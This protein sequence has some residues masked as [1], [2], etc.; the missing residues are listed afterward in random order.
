MDELFFTLL[1]PDSR[2]AF[3]SINGGRKR[4]GVR[5]EWSDSEDLNPTNNG[6]SERGDK[7][8]GGGGDLF[9]CIN[10]GNVLELIR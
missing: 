7:G 2:G 1:D 3:P 6:G 10:G 5:G 8:E 9:P 4:G